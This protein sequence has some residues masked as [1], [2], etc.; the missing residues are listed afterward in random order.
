MEG[1]GEVDEGGEREVTKEKTERL[2]Q[3]GTPAQPRRSGV[4]GDEAGAEA[5]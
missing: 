1:E 5:A 3:G 2:G 4:S